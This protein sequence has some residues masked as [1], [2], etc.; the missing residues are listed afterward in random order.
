MKRG[1]GVSPRRSSVASVLIA[2]V[3][4]TA[5]ALA[6]GACSSSSTTSRSDSD[7]GAEGGDVADASCTLL[8]DACSGAAACC[9][10]YRGFAVDDD[11]GCKARASTAIACRPPGTCGSLPGMLGCYERSEDAGSV[12]RYYTQTLLPGPPAPLARC[13][14]EDEKRTILY[15]DCP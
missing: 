10:P 8:G 2:A 13:S 11:A 14:T 1:R 15:P 9:P 5:V 12:T 4:A 6:G 3:A 7:S